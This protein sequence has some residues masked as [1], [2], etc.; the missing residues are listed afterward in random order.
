MVLTITQNI[1]HVHLETCQA[2]TG[3]LTREPVIGSHRLWPL[4][5]KVVCHYTQAISISILMEEYCCSLELHTLLLCCLCISLQ[6]LHRQILGRHANMSCVLKL[7]TW[8]LR[9]TQNAHA[10]TWAMTMWKNDTHK[11]PVT[12]MY[13]CT[14][15]IT[16]D[17]IPSWPPVTKCGVDTHTNETLVLHTVGTIC[18]TW[19]ISAAH[20]WHNLPR[21]KH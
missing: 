15:S 21:M 17:C 5:N 9:D 16:A 3:P 2:N 6:S 14:I 8:P 11:P 19:N 18:H 7:N 20:C 10:N 1:L 12:S 13:H 4:I